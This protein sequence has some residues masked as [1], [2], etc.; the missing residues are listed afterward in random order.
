MK[1]KIDLLIPVFLFFLGCELLLGEF[2]PWLISAVFFIAGLGI[3]K[4][5]RYNLFF[6]R[7]PFLLLGGI[8]I[9]FSFTNE[10]IFQQILITF[11]LILLYLALSN[12]KGLLLLSEQKKLSNTLEESDK[13]DCLKIN[14]A[15]SFITFFLWTSGISKACLNFNISVS[16]A[17]VLLF[18]VIAL[19]FHQSLKISNPESSHPLFYSFVIGFMMTELAWVLSFWPLEHFSIGATLLVVYWFWWDILG[20]SLKEKLNKKIIFEDLI[21]GT[22][23]IGLILLSTKWLPI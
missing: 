12:T 18:V 10:R 14:Q 11:S 21:F 4:A 7:L 5:V 1:R 17:M 16:L 8:V 13:T 19:L 6:G 9:S 2:S 23:G 15:I 20:R 22:L 3:L